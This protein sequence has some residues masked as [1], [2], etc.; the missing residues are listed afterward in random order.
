MKRK[1][2]DQE[3]ELCEKGIKL[4]TSRIKNYKQELAYTEDTLK[5]HE[6]WNDYLKEKKIEDHNKKMELLKKTNK[7]LRDQIISESKALKT[8]K[9]QLTEGIEIKKPSGVN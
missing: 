3:R 2:N 7:F 8:E 6:K 9:N 4:R 5:F 1:L